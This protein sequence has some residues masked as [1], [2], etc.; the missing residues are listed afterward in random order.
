[1]TVPLEVALV[2]AALVGG[3]LAS[4]SGAV[5][6]YIFGQRAV[7]ASR[8]AELA[9]LKAQE[10]AATAQSAAL[11]AAKQLVEV[12]KTT[13]PLLQEISA[14]GRLTHGI[15]NSARTATLRAL[16]GLARRVANDHPDDEAA[17][18]AADAAERDLKAALAEVAATI[19]HT[20]T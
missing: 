5:L 17:Q 13:T 6:T 12:A 1:M 18:L 14:T 11:D 3:T 15:V 2:F 20:E 19:G 10:D 7:K 9:T 8:K 16:A 4:A